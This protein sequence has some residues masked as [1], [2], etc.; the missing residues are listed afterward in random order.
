LE[1]VSV[2]NHCLSM[3]KEEQTVLGLSSNHS[4]FAYVIK[5]SEVFQL[6]DLALSHLFLERFSE[7]FYNTLTLDIPF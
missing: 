2:M 3:S 6:L 4:R 7:D 5:Q 1:W